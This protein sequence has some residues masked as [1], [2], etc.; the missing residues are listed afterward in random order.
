MQAVLTAGL[1]IGRDCSSIVVRFHDDQARAKDHQ[2]CEHMPLPC[3][4]DNNTGGRP[5]CGNVELEFFYAHRRNPPGSSFNEDG[6]A[7]AGW[8]VSASIHTHA[9]GV[10]ILPVGIQTPVSGQAFR[11][12]SSLLFIVPPFWLR[13]TR[14]HPALEAR[15]GWRHK[16]SVGEWRVGR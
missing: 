4:A 14:P 3:A 12:V 5:R 2:E 7:E 13:Q 16:P 11:I 1:H 15:I 9:S 10:R 8:M 6:A